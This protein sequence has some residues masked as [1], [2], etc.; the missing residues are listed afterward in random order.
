M[1]ELCH[2]KINGALY[3]GSGECFFL[4]GRR[5]SGKQGGADAGDA[6][7]QAQEARSRPSLSTFA[8]PAPHGRVPHSV[9]LWLLITEIR[10]Y[11]WR[12]RALHDF[13]QGWKEV[14]TSQVERKANEARL[15]SGLM[16]SRMAVYFHLLP[17][18][19][20]L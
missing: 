12:I 1:A 4:L 10:N 18:G 6:R 5:A 14:S 7:S 16:A 2:H 8:V 3:V 15:F 19:G 17:Q 13:A 20:A 9:L 11:L